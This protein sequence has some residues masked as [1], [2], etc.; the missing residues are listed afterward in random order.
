MDF[1]S[2]LVTDQACDYLST[3]DPLHT[4]CYLCLVSALAVHCCLTYPL[5]RYRD[6]EV[7]LL[8]EH[9]PRTRWLAACDGNLSHVDRHEEAC[10]PHSATVQCQCFGACASDDAQVQTV[11]MKFP[12]RV[13][14]PILPCYKK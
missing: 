5:H 6:D 14:H 9:A 3:I 13:F 1:T 4:R 8:H 7:L 12:F 11:A 2:R 10:N